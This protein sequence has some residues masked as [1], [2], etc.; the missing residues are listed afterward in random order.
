MKEMY[1]FY[2]NKDVDA[3]TRLQRNSYVVH[4]E[5]VQ[6][7][8]KVFVCPLCNNEL[9]DENLDNSLYN[10]YNEYLK[11]FDLSFA[12]LKEIREYYNLSQDLF[13][14]ALGWSKRS[15]V[16]YENAGSLPQKQYLLIYKKINNNKHEFINILKM[17]RKFLGDELYFKI[18]NI[19]G[20]DLDL[21]TINVFLYVLKNNYLTKTQIM[22]NMFSIDF[23]FFKEYSRPITSFRYA[24]G[25]YGP[26]IDNKDAILNLLVKQ[27]YLEMVNNEED[28]IL[29]KPIAEPD[30]TLF[31]KNE[32]EVM[33]EVLSKLKG[34]SAN[35]LT[36]WSHKFKGWLNTKDGELISYS[37]AKDFDL[38]KNW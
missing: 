20:T 1:C 29:F 21:K 10:I 13:A 2:C 5:Q 31:A 8:E 15:I 22:K 14:K 36:C 23:Q 34:K 11:I 25:T 30:M 19:I 32:V 37:Y 33:N 38:Y 6:V 35:N 7:E 16:R 9:Y 12:K 18:L 27:N 28:N 3:I 26:I 17:N 24:H 4:Q